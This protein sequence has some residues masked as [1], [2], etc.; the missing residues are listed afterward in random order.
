MLTKCREVCCIRDVI[1]FWYC[2]FYNFSTLHDTQL[3]NALYISKFI[4]YCILCTHVDSGTRPASKVTSV[5][6]PKQCTSCEWLI[7]A[8]VYKEIGLWNYN[9]S[10]WQCTFNGKD[11]TLT[12]LPPVRKFYITAHSDKSSVIFDDLSCW[13]A[14]SWK[15]RCNVTALPSSTHLRHVVACTSYTTAYNGK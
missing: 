2:K 13:S 14:V 12:A 10:C 7:S 9:Q 1:C 4:T 11:F 15:E 3:H 5:S 6:P 8:E